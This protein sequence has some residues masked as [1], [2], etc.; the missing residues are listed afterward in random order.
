MYYFYNV[1]F[2]FNDVIQQKFKQKKEWFDFG[3]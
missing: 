3:V 2:Y 1:I